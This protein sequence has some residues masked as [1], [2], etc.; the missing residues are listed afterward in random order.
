MN[1]FWRIF[2]LEFTAAVR[3]RALALLLFASVG[4]MFAAPLL[5]IGDGTDEGSRILAVHYSLGGVAALLSIALLASATGTIASER[6]NKRLQLTLV[7]PVRYMVVA[8][9]KMAALV[10]LGA[11]VLGAAT[12][13]EA[14]RSDLSRPCRHVLSPIMPTPHEE[15]AMAYEAFMKDPNTPAAV[16]RAKK[17]VVLRLLAQR[18]LDRYDTIEPNEVVH[19]SFKVQDS[20]LPSEGLAVRLRFTNAYDM[21]QDVHGD[22][23]LRVGDCEWGGSVSNMTQAVV[24]IPMQLKRTGATI[25]DVAELTFR[26]IGRSALM[27]RPRR[28]I[29]LLVPAD[30]FGWN[31]LRAYVEL[32]AMLSMLVAFG[33]FL[34]AGLGRP[35]ALFTAIVA[36]LV[37]EMSPA[38]IEQ[39]PDELETDRLDSIGLYITRAAAE[40]THPISSLVPLENLSEDACVERREVVRTVVSNIV[41]A[42]LLLSFLAALLM[43]RKVD[44]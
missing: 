19:W 21:R 6:A 35:V 11:L 44:P 3:S 4:W 8:L 16:R 17:S 18:S 14:F 34:G 36:L 30:G 28:D 15:A 13:V 42:P 22:L 24:E 38:V 29:N 20:D 40:A 9:A 25:G 41:L 27:F 23:L 5:F 33:V 32:V 31:L 26:N 12:V 10:S 7:R 43:P 1:S 37:S 2:S 39:Y